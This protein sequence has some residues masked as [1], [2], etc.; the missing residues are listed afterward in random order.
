MQWKKNEQT[1]KGTFIG[2]VL[3][4]SMVSALLHEIQ[5]L[6]RE[7]C[8]CQWVRLWVNGRINGHFFLS[9]FFSFSFLSFIF[10]L[11][12]AFV[13]IVLSYW[14]WIACYP[15]PLLDQVNVKSSRGSYGGV[16]PF[17]LLFFFFFLLVAFCFFC[18]KNA[19]IRSLAKKW[20]S[21]AKLRWCRTRN[22]LFFRDSQIGCILIV[23]QVKW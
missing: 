11:F 3:D 23:H 22:T 21:E 4:L 20:A 9:F 16:L 15:S 2:P 5:D 13:S 8:V 14:F 12:Y 7:L 19:S 18:S 10:V 1:K 6:V 17:L